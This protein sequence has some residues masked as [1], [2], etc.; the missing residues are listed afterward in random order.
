MPGGWE[1]TVKGDSAVHE[2][3]K[4][5]KKLVERVVLT[6][7]EL[8]KIAETIRQT[9]PDRIRMKHYHT[10]ID[11]KATS[12]LQLKHS[13]YSVSLTEG[14]STQIRGKAAKDYV[15]LFNTVRDIVMAKCA[16]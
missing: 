6:R 4:V 11:D 12:Y 13:K 14:A 16:K 15:Y 1:I 10:A 2:H 7:N 9:R 3:Y 5:G 8:D